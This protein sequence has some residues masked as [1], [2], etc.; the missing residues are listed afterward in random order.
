[1]LEEDAPDRNADER[2][3]KKEE[4]YKIYFSAGQC[5]VKIFFSGQCLAKYSL[6]RTLDL[7]ELNGRVVA[8][9]R[10][11]Q[12]TSMDLIMLFQQKRHLIPTLSGTGIETLKNSL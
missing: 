9:L 8:S 5:L 6:C 4:G 1:M 2:Q 12:D 11:L 10:I 7:P 3:G